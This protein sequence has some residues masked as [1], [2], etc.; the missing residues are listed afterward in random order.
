MESGKCICPLCDHEIGPPMDFVQEQKI[1]IIVR[2]GFL[3]TILLDS[4]NMNP[5]WT[6]GRNYEVLRGK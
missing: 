2:S 1:D 3:Q 5:S 4:P 6:I